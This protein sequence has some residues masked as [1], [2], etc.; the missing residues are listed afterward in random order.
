[1]LLVSAWRRRVATVKRASTTGFC[2]RANWEM[3]K[4][5]DDS[6]D[7]VSEMPGIIREC[8]SRYFLASSTDWGGRGGVRSGMS[9]AEVATGEGGDRVGVGP[10]VCDLVLIRVVRPLLILLWEPELVIGL[11]KFVRC[12]RV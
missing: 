8:F 10:L 6:S 3:C 5:V 9:L 2:T 7:A 12:R 1:M 4:M 11:K